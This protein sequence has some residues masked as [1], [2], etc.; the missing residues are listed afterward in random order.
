MASTQ[1]VDEQ[2]T[3]GFDK[4]LNDA[5]ESRN[6][7]LTEGLTELITIR[8]FPN[9]NSFDTAYY[10][11]CAFV[12]QLIAI[13]GIE[14]VL[15][16]YFS[17]QGIKPLQVELN[18]IIPDETMSSYLFR[19]IEDNFNLGN[20]SYEQSFAGSIQECLINYYQEKIK[21]EVKNGLMTSNDALTMINAYAT[22][23]VTKDTLTSQGIDCRI[24]PNIEY[25][26][27]LFEQLKDTYAKT[28]GKKGMR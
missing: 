24:Y 6:R 17:G 10:F 16:A 25:S 27:S 21:Q 8:A 28:K 9:G 14:P 11:E 23:L 15:K 5:E 2:I 13:V 4:P 1:K 18:K 26:L 3:S 19:M 20:T 7:G 12:S 22:I